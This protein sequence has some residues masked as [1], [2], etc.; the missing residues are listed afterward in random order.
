MLTALMPTRNRPL[1]C[2]RQLRFLRDIG[3]PYW[4]IEPRSISRASHE[5]WDISRSCSSFVPSG[6]PGAR[7]NDSVEETESPS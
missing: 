1:H 4:L 3:F 5:A 7:L 6:G 2:A